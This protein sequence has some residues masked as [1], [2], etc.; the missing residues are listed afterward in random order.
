MPEII[1]AGPWLQWH[2]DRFIPPAEAEV[3]ATS[4]AGCQAIQLGRTFAT[5]FHPEVDEGML[6]KW[7]NS[8]TG[9]KELARLGTTAETLLD[10]TREHVKLSQPNA[11]RIV[12]WFLDNVS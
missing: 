10:A 7:V 3:L 6:T 11:A 9:V 4:P 5:Q 1:A 2:Y 12:D 8:D